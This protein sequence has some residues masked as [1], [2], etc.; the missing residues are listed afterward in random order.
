MAI[1]AGRF[2]K[3]IIFASDMVGGYWSYGECMIIALPGEMS[4][5]LWAKN[6]EVY[7]RINAAATVALWPHKSDE[8][9]Y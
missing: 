6:G 3:E 7:H 5:I 9:S 8:K 4:P 1:E 2:V